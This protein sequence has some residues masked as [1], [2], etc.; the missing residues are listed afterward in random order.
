M[1]R[2]Y[3]NLRLPAYCSIFLFVCCFSLVEAQ[4]ALLSREL[5]QTI[6]CDDGTEY[7]VWLSFDNLHNF[8][9]F[10]SS[11]FIEYDD[12]TARLYGT[13]VNNNDANLK[14]EVD[15][16]FGGRTYSTPANSPK[17]NNCYTASTDDW[18]YYTTTEGTFTGL[19]GAAGALISF[20][21]SGPSFQIGTGANVTDSEV[22]SA[23]GWLN[24]YIDSQPTDSNLNLQGENGDFNFRLNGSSLPAI[25]DNL[26][27]GGKI[28]DYEVSA[29]AFDPELIQSLTSPSGG[30]SEIIQ[31]LWL[32][33]TDPDLPWSAWT[34]IPDSDAPSYDPGYITT[35]T[36]FLRCA[37]RLGCSNYTG[38]SNIIAKIVN[39]DATNCADDALTQDVAGHA[40]AY[41]SNS[42]V[43]TPE[44]ILGDIDEVIAAF[45]DQDDLMTIKLDG[46]LEAG[47]NFTVSWKQRSYS[48]SY[49]GPSHLNVYESE[50][51]INF[52]LN[53]S[54]KTSINYYFTHNTLT[55]NAK[56]R[57]LKLENGSTASDTSP[58]FE[59]DAISY[60]NTRCA[61][62][63]AQSCE[64]LDHGTADNYALPR[65][66]W[67]NFD[68]SGVQEY[69]LSDNGGTFTEL[70]D[71]SVL[72]EGI[73]TNLADDCY[74]WQFSVK[75]THKRNWNEWSALGRSYKA[76]G[77]VS[78]EDHKSW[79]YYEVDDK[80]SAFEGLNCHA[81]ES[82]KIT[83]NPS[84]Y[85][86]GFQLGYGANV[87]DSD[88]GF[89]GWFAFSGD[90]NGHGDFNADLGNCLA[91]SSAHIG[92]Q[93]WED[94]N[95]NGQKD[96]GE[97]GIS[98]VFVFLEDENGVAIPGV[99]F[100]LTDA[101]G[102][103]A[104]EDL[105]AGSYRV[106]F[107]TPIGYLLTDNDQGDD[108]NDSD[109]NLIDGRSPL[110]NLSEGDTN[111]NV[112][113]GYVVPVKVGSRIW[114]DENA[115]GM[116]DA[117]EPGVPNILVRLVKAGPDDTF[118]TY[119]DVFVETQATDSE[120]EF[121]FQQV[122]AGNYAIKIE[123]SSFN[124]DYILTIKDAGDEAMDSDFEPST[125]YTAPFSITSGIEENL[126]LDGGLEPVFSLPVELITFTA[127]LQTNG[128]V[129]LD[130]A[131]AWEEHNQYFI[132]QRSIDGERFEPIGSVNG[133]GTT[134]NTNHYHF[135]DETPVYGRNFYRLKQVDIDGQYS[136]SSVEL[137]ILE[138]EGLADV[139]AFP[140][141]TR[142]FIRLRVVRPF[143]TAATVRLVNAYGQQIEL[144]T[145]EAGSDY[146]D[147][148]LRS[149]EAGFYFVR[150]EYNDFKKLIY[151]I[152]KIKD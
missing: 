61:I 106:R 31:Y 51:G 123:E 109:A 118:N 100:Q 47:Q 8:Y 91:Q 12:G 103:Y 66:V 142:D 121:E 37:R 53:T 133:Q 130:W 74:Q 40:A 132:V 137:V 34:Q 112:D 50:D 49:S 65:T 71:G 84:D 89:S 116:Q 138:A 147:L 22:F 79:F 149:Y 134:T 11:A 76:N 67:L 110:I 129:Q 3:Q 38:E 14:F 105:S 127:K 18:Y 140:N 96:S 30:S 13:I 26:T 64:M 139:I 33:S 77:F 17:N 87:K 44:E 95:G 108:E 151:R 27:D 21:R 16:T 68:G 144:L 98:N 94:L 70:A 141:P 63:G 119:D 99:D 83:H 135:V 60:N 73:A 23:S 82:L 24:L 107:A 122:R 146:L 86:Y 19:D 114:L 9:Q 25:C 41:S 113:A 101:D 56:T 143:E 58:D 78:D 111:D 15:A 125:G 150:I 62:D 32:S 124:G 93:I 126:E 59:I 90:Y 88:Y 42:G 2:F 28:S 55:T 6:K 115:D 45:Y 69:S 131:T 46:E 80:Y 145:A 120:G 10:T 152:A 29:T 43:D 97:P 52:T 75:L 48:N 57:Y 85:T 72:L 92:D 35:T 54:L 36:Y 4:E 1:K 148:D 5:S 39:G 117:D 7:S 81:G 104:F 136:F 20:D 128:S 102:K